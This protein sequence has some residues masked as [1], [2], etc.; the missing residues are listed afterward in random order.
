MVAN[1]ERTLH[2]GAAPIESDPLHDNLRANIDV[3]LLIIDF[4]T[5]RRLR[6]NGRAER[7]QDGSFYVHAQ[8]V[9]TNCPKYIQARGLSSFRVLNRLHLMSIGPIGSRRDSI[10]PAS[11]GNLIGGAVLVALLFWY[12]YGRRPQQ[13]QSLRRASQIVREGLEEVEGS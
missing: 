11:L 9:Y 7:Q 2:I 10:V 5:R 3:G 8:Q 13:R 1:D 12:T 4:A 6:V